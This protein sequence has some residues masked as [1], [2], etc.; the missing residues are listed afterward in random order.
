MSPKTSATHP[1]TVSVV[2]LIPGEIVDEVNDGWAAMVAE[3]HELLPADWSLPTAW[4]GNGVYDSVRRDA[5]LGTW[6]E[7]PACGDSRA[8]SGNAF[9]CFGNDTVAW[10]L[11][12]LIESRQMSGPLSIVETM[13]HEL[14]HAV[15]NRLHQVGKDYLVWP[16]MELQA[17]CI[18]GAMLYDASGNGLIAVPVGGVDEL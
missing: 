4:N 18:A 3:W 11:I 17:D 12:F 6:M 9:Y 2:P 7:G 8:E 15:Q 10:D 13:A 1:E 5:Y 14:G 16:Q